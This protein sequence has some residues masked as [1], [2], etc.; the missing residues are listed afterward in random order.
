MNNGFGMPVVD[1]GKTS[2]D[3]RFVELLLSLARHKTLVFGMPVLFGAVAFAATLAMSPS[4]TSV[5]KVMP[6]QQQQSSVAAMLGQLGGLAGA[7]A[8]GLGAMRNPGDLYVGMLESRTVADALIN[9]FKLKERYHV[10]T[11]EEART[12]LARVSLMVNGKKDGLISITASDADP[13]VAADMANAYVDELLKITQS[14]AVSEA[15]QRRMF[16]EK[17]LR[18]AGTDLAA[19]EIALRNTQQKTGMIQPDKQVQA[20]ITSVA[21][22]K[23]AVAAKEVQLNAMR[24]FAAPANPELRRAEEELR[25]LTAQLRKMEGSGPSRTGDFMVPTGQIPEVGVEYVRKI[26]DVK[27]NEAIFE[28]LAKQ[29]ELAKI[30]EAKDSP[31]IQSFEKALP[32]ERKSAPRTIFITLIGAMCGLMVGILIAFARDLYLRASGNPHGNSAWYALANELRWS[33]KR[34]G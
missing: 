19:S 26:R 3:I 11:M 21:Q 12:K 32:A 33:R 29:F 1:D 31:L 6:P 30:D 4:F 18:D 25:T 7:A 10:K 27:F 13:Q 14:M 20:I 17:Q 28:L 2:E 5:A 8:G 9:R 34:A 23:A 16:F 15:A 22:L 24:T